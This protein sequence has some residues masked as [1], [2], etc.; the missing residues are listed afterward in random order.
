ME[1]SWQGHTITV[2]ALIRAG[3]DLNVQDKGGTTA[4][5]IASEGGHV[6]TVQA[7]IGAGADCTIQDKV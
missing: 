1:A 2:Q 7:L 4:L 6:A 5:M 3:A